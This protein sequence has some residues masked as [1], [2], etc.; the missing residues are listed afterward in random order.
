[1]YACFSKHDE[2]EN[3]FYLFVSPMPVTPVTH[4]PPLTTNEPPPTTQEPPSITHETPKISTKTIQENVCF[5]KKKLR[6]LDPTEYIL[7]KIIIIRCKA[8]T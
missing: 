4:E 1:M 7:R 8:K 5:N 2:N 3:S 6:P